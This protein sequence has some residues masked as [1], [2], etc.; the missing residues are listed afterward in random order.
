VARLRERQPHAVF[1]VAPVHPAR[2]AQTVSMPAGLLA[3]DGPEH[4]GSL[5]RLLTP[6]GESQT[7]I[8]GGNGMWA[9]RVAYSC[10]G[11]RGLGD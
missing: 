6:K 4:P 5:A 9:G 8:P 3:R 11:S 1:A 2:R 7:G 10:G